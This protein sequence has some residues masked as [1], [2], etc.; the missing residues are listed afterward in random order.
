MPN[1]FDRFYQADKSRTRKE[2][3]G[4]GLGLA[5]AKQIIDSYNGNIDV[6]SIEGKG[7]K[8]IVVLPLAEKKDYN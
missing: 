5:I 4:S 2:N 8:F 1:V 6:E 7:T 3:K